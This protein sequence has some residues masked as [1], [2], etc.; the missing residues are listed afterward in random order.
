MSPAVPA[1]APHLATATATA[2]ATAAATATGKAPTLAELRGAFVVEHAFDKPPSL[3]EWVRLGPVP[4]PIPNPPARRRALRLHDLHHLL[5]GYQTN[6]TGEWQISAWECAGGMHRDAV[7]WTFCLMGLTAGMIAAP[8]LTVRAFARGR[9]GRSLFG[10]DPNV[11]DQLTLAEGHAFCGTAD[12][13]PDATAGDAVRAAAWGFLGIFTALFPPL[14]WGLSRLGRPPAV[15]LTRAI[16][17][18]S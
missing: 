9:R 14:A 8:R 17:A 5:T 6:W 10:Q 12:P 16:A 13:Q 3:I 4:V 1:T 7:A 2:T 11:I 15:Q 18:V